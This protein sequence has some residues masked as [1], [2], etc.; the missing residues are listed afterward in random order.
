[1]NVQ[2]ESLQYPKHQN[3]LSSCVSFTW[4]LRN[5]VLTHDAHLFANLSRPVAFSLA[6][7]LTFKTETP[8]QQKI[9]AVSNYVELQTPYPERF[10][11]YR[12]EETAESLGASDHFAAR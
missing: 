2:W 10:H 1:M 9:T 4:S 7:I 8:L 12:P 6:F 5:L 3:V 11:T